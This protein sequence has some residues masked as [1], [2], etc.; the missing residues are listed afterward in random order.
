MFTDY[1]ENLDLTRDIE[2]KYLDQIIRIKRI[3]GYIYRGDTHRSNVLS[4]IP[5]FYGTKESASKYIHNGEYLKRYTTMRELILLNISND[6]D[7]VNKHILIF[8]KNLIT[9]MPQ[10]DLDIKMCIILLQICFGL[11]SGAYDNMGLS[12]REV[13]E[14]FLKDGID[15]SDIRIFFEFIHSMLKG[16]AIP[17]RCS[18]KVFDKL[19]M[20]TLKKILKPLKIDGIFYIQPEKDINEKKLLCETAN[21]YYKE[22]TCVPTEIVIFDSANDLGGVEFWKKTKHSFVYIS[23][24]DNY[25]KHI[26]NNYSR[27][28][29]NDLYTLS[30]KNK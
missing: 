2:N 6:D 10:F 28:S 13:S 27:L 9:E 4:L 23:K 22:N 1:K 21:K 11:I 3:N 26:K 17:S 7:T 5:R 20:R 15:F 8:F 14:Y 19:L 12:V 24:K 30:K 16:E 29:L 25:N 18:I